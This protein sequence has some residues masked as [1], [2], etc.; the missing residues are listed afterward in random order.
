MRWDEEPNGIVAARKAAIEKLKMRNKNILNDDNNNNTM[1]TNNPPNPNLRRRPKRRPPPRPPSPT[2][3]DQSKKY[4]PEVID[5]NKNND[6]DI[7]PQEIPL[8]DNNN[9]VEKKQPNNNNNNNNRR[10]RRLT[11]KQKFF[12]S[13]K[14]EL[15]FDAGASPP[16]P[17]RVAKGRKQR[18]QQRQQREASL[19]R[20]QKRS[21]WM[22]TYNWK[23][24]KEKK[25]VGDSNQNIINNRYVKG[26]NNRTLINKNNKRGT[27]NNNR[28]GGNRPG[29]AAGR[30]SK[31]PSTTSSS[32]NNNVDIA[33]II[34]DKRGQANIEKYKKIIKEKDEAIQK[35]KANY[36]SEQ[37]NK[38]KKKRKEKMYSKTRHE[39]NDV[40]SSPP[41]G[42]SLY[43]Q[44]LLENT[45]GR[46]NNNNKSYENVSN[47]SDDSSSS[48]SSDSSSSS[49]NSDTSSDDDQ[50]EEQ[51]FESPRSSWKRQL[52]PGSPSDI[53]ILRRC[54]TLAEYVQY[55]ENKY[56]V[57]MT[58]SHWKQIKQVDLQR[59][60]N[61]NSGGITVGEPA[62]LTPTKEYDAPEISSLEYTGGDENEQKR[63]RAMIKAR[64]AADVE[65]ERRRRR[66]EELEEIE[67][68]E[69]IT[70]KEYVDGAIESERIRRINDTAGETAKQRGARRLSLNFINDLIQKDPT[71]ITKTWGY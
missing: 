6:N 50:E 19:R 5:V 12:Q 66:E 70:K 18:L 39:R 68:V 26:R 46:N 29:R 71:F 49:S 31:R 22:S 23:P 28:Q 10:R 4:V 69:K 52:P 40:G 14:T 55:L 41:R 7:I 1:Q 3:Y 47:S 17:I 58:E 15:A 56:G 57:D 37:L 24:V 35:L 38:K 64:V 67:Q 65:A 21:S 54:D 11:M 20:Y 48:S 16:P 59:N 45:V 32:N 43:E 27:N 36:D 63:V 61:K 25:Y 51:T 2:Q 8:N 44:V 9:E 33:T 62:P 13:M 53:A 42:T 60:N 34:T 30:R